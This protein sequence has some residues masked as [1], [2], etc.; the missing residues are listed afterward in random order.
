MDDKNSPVIEP[1]VTEVIDATI[2]SEETPAEDTDTASPVVEADQS[3]AIILTNLESLIKS[4]ISS[5][6]RDMDEFKKQ[7][8]MYDSVFENSATYREHSEKAEEANKLKS[9]TRSEIMKQPGV[10]AVASKMKDIRAEISELRNEL[11][12]Y[13][14]EYQRMTGANQIEDDNGIIRDISISAKLV[15]RGGK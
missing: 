6:E 15:K 2:V 13:L 7:K 5:L 11:S 12:E 4:H 8:E 9:A 1:E 3:Q 14:Q 10:I